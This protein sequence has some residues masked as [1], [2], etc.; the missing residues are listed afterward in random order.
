MSDKHKAYFDTLGDGEKKKFTAMS[1]AD[2]DAEMEKTKKRAED[3][4]IYKAQ[5][6]KIE[7]LQKALKAITDEKDLDVA[8]R[9][10]KNLGMT[11]TD[12]GDVLMKARRGDAE[13]MK[14]I[15]AHMGTLIKQRGAF[16]QTSKAFVELGTAR[17]SSAGGEGLTAHDELVARAAELRKAKPDLTEAQ[18]YEKVYSDPAN[19]ELRDREVSERMAKI[20]RVA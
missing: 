17:G 18:A 19:R 16:E 9:D 11:T 15:E 4:P 3:D 6:A 12:A 14:K 5:N 20:H 7:E 13:A 8:K 2:R 1:P 10:A